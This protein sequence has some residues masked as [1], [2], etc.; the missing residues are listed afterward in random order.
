M[1]E[2]LSEAERRC[3]LG[4]LESYS[5]IL[6]PRLKELIFQAWSQFLLRKPGVV[7]VAPL[8][9]SGSRAPKSSQI[10]WATLRGHKEVLEKSGAH[11]HLLR[12]HKR[13]LAKRKPDDWLVL[14]DDY[15]GSGRTAAGVLTEVVQAD[16]T[17]T[18]ENVAVVAA[19]AQSMAA[20]HLNG[21]C[22]LDV[23]LVRHRCLSDTQLVG[24]LEQMRGLGRRLRFPEC[25]VLGYENTEAALTL[26]RTPNNTLPMFWTNRRVG[27]AVWPAPFP[28]GNDR[29]T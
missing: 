14:V 18:S 3:A 12:S 26:R 6:E 20:D 7:W 17:R 1:L 10:I 29:E 23:A 22:K 9:K 2:R 27:G 15:I 28:R 4:V 24:F 8:L 13:H 11:V 25:E 21:R 16:P 5:V 19:V